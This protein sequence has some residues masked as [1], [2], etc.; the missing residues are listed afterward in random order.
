MPNENTIPPDAVKQIRRVVAFYKRQ[1]PLCESLRTAILNL[2]LEQK[3]RKTLPA[4]SIQSRLKDPG[5]LEH[6]LFR[7]YSRAKENGEAFSVTSDNLFKKVQDL[8][9]V[10]ILHLHTDEFQDI[11]ACLKKAFAAQKY[12]I[13][14]G[15]TSHAWDEEYKE[16]FGRIKIHNE[17]RKSLYTSVHY[18][19]Q[20]S[21]GS[22]I[23]CELQV[24]TVAEELWG[25]VSH[26]L[27]YPETST[28]IA[29]T[30]QLLVLA[31]LTATC[32]RLVDSLFRCHKESLPKNHG[33]ITATSSKAASKRPA[34]TTTSRP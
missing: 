2:L 34:R 31:R 4:H 1:M 12:A 23:C 28:F 5:H 10:R 24:R 19:V 30:E 16:H 6:K 25:E 9:G 7:Q 26:K 33:R 11:D 22:E 17:P 21:V 20:P 32:N 27:N 15:P 18:L 3:E 13:I 29:T 8:I 14:E